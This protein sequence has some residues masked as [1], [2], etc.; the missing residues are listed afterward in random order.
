MVIDVIGEVRQ[1]LDRLAESA[2]AV[3]RLYETGFL[4][5]TKPGVMIETAKNA[6]LFGPQATM[7]IQGGRK[8]AGLPALV[9]ERGTLTYR[10]IDNQSWALARGLQSLGVTEGSVVGLLCRDHR[11]LI[12]AMVACG[13]L[14]A[15]LVLM[16]TGF[17]K[18]QFAEVCE[19]EG[20]KVVLH[21]SEF[22]GLLDALPADMPRVLT[23][24]DEGHDEGHDVPESAQTLDAIVAANT[25]E[26]LP[27]PSK[28]GGS[29]I[30]TSGT[31][32]LPK[33]APRSSVSP[34][35]TAQII[36]RIPFPRKGTMVIVSPIFH[37]TGWATYTVGAALGNKVVTARR[38]N[39][40]RTLQLI[41]EH[42]AQM[43]VA[44]PTMLHRIVELGPDIIG[45]YDTS[46]LTTILIAGSA[47]SPELSNRVQDTFGD[48]L[49]N[50]YG[51][52]ECAI[53]SVATPAELR[54]A[55][56]T[57]GRAPVTCEVVLYDEN[58]RRIK[59]N[60]KRG[61]IF[62]RNGAP[63]AG[64]T[65]GRTKQIIDGYMSSGDMGH[66]D[67]HGLLFVDG[68]DDDMIV[69]GG[70]NVFPQE[71][72]ELLAERDDVY[73]AAVVGVDD[74]E[75][76]KRLRAFIVSQPGAAQD[77]DEIKA[78]VKNNLARHKVPRDVV[79]I[80]ELPRNTT[81]KLLRRVLIE[82]DV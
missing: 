59:G 55:P 56:G 43:L 20:V 12:L 62:V 48:V 5:L 74:V 81:G 40:E 36:D 14:G 70:E 63:F 26:P 45:K 71:V 50:L 75:W 77:A 32:G 79:F 47:L 10:Q 49:H 76:G 80:D 18:P 6:P 41:A 65:D 11:G 29:V 53:A 31:T 25:T 1:K 27:P 82:M 17:A 51:S 78:F 46:S 8:Y 60:N 72:E 38:F 33:G 57:A 3:R 52:T 68:R 15:R 23:W 28:A 58:D 19:R 9:D 30:L 64:Y 69:S 24:V 67:E 54:L 2:Q 66:F 61:R 39:A 4:D 34:L 37:S 73:D 35:A 16:N 7:A 21:D 13:K 42:K 44:V 22:L